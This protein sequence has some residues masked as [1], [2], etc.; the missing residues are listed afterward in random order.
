MER[1]DENMLLLRQP[2]QERSEEGSGCK[3][4]WAIGLLGRPFVRLRLRSLSAGQVKHLEAVR[5]PSRMYHL[6]SLVAVFD[7][8]CPQGLVALD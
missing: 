2:N 8:Y 7:K 4:E 5:A 3:I 1:E 6:D